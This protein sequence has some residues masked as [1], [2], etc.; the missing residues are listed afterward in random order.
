[1]VDTFIETLEYFPRGLVYVALG[2]VVLYI[3][4]WILDLVTP[5]HVGDQLGEKGN[6]ALG[7]SITGYFLGVIIVFVAVLY[8]PFGTGEEF[9]WQFDA[10]FGYDVLEVFLYSLGAIAVLNL[11]RFLVDRLV[12]FKF[13]VEKEV[14]EDQNAGSGAVEMAVYIAVALVIASALA[15]YEVT[16]LGA[17]APSILDEIIRSVAFFLLGVVVLVLYALYYQVVTAYDI[18]DE[19]E[20]DNVAVGVA[21]AANLIAIAI[22]V[23]KAVTGEFV[24]W[25]E[26]LI[27]FATF[28]VIG[29]ILL[30]VVRW[31]I[32]K[33]I[34]PRVKVAE[35]LSEARNLSVAFVVGSIVIGVSLVLFF[36]I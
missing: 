34:F 30:L 10:D 14:I 6:T 15:G 9:Q 17:V 3:A 24:G 2:I 19:I 32:D 20:K 7:L 18:H 23:F 33:A 8:T 4:K 13:N 27:S 35:E 5:Y 31:I 16:Q 12:L 25:G 22:V 29:F 36:A 26:S 1:M 11:T 21:M 28:A